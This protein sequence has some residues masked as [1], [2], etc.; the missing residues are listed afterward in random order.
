MEKKSRRLAESVAY[1]GESWYIMVSHHPLQHVAECL[2]G[3]K[4]F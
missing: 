3:T 2:A 4:S 1:P